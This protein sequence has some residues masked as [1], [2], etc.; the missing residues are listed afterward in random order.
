KSLEKIQ[1][2]LSAYSNALNEIGRR[3]AQAEVTLDR[4]VSLKAKTLVVETPNET[5]SVTS[6]DKQKAKAMIAFVN[7]DAKSGRIH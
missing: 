2:S 4:L 7:L 1:L 3:L 5:R 6:Q